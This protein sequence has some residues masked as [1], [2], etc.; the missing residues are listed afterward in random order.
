MRGLFRPLRTLAPHL[1]RPQGLEKILVAKTGGEFSV[2]FFGSSYT[3]LSIAPSRS[4]GI[5]EALS[6]MYCFPSAALMWDSIVV[7][8][9]VGQLG[10]TL[11]RA[12]C[13]IV[14]QT[15]ECSGVWMIVDV[16]ISRLHADEVPFEFA[17][18]HKRC[19]DFHQGCQH[20]IADYLAAPKKL[21]IPSRGGEWV[22][23]DEEWTVLEHI[24]RSKMPMKH[25]L[26]SMVDA[27]LE[28]FG[29]GIAW[30]FLECAGSN[31]PAVVACYQRMLKDGRWDALLQGIKELRCAA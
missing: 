11:P 16:T 28:K 15:I 6:W 31:R 3:T 30:R 10:L 25:D 7:N 21:L 18:M 12:R 4:P 26:K 19:I 17:P 8:A 13:A 14:L 2:G 22:L 1:F 24:V 29:R 9:R 20:L 27:I 23:S 5:L